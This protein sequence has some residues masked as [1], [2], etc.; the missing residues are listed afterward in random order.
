MFI[1]Q[2]LLLRLRNNHS[3]HTTEHVINID[4]DVNGIKEKTIFWGFIL[5]KIILQHVIVEVD[6]VGQDWSCPVIG[7]PNPSS[8]PG[9][10]NN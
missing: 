5:L 9:E 8:A 3:Q 2:P 4:G 1:T 10:D 7:H 6:Q